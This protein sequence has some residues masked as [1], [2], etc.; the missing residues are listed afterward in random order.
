MARR[1][2]GDGGR[3]GR[4]AA[5]AI[6]A[7]AAAAAVVLCR[8]PAA[9]AFKYNLA[10][11]TEGGTT[12]ATLMLSEGHMFASH[13][14]PF[15]TDGVSSISAGIRLTPAAGGT[16][17]RSAAIN[18]WAVHLDAE[19]YSRVGYVVPDVDGGQMEL[20][21]CTPSLYAQRVCGAGTV[22]GGLIVHEDAD[23][24][25][26]LAPALA[27]LTP[28]AS[29]VD[30]AA[31]ME[32]AVAGQQYLVVA[33]CDTSTDVPARGLP[34]LH[35]DVDLAFINP[36]GYLP[37]AAYGLLPFYGTLFIAYTLL[38]AG[39]GAIAALKRRY[40]L[41]LQLAV[42]GVMLAGV[43]EMALFF[44]TYRSKNATGVPTPCSECGTPTSDYMAAVVWGVL[45]RAVSR[46]LLLA[47]AAGFGVVH[48]TLTR[49]TT[50]GIVALCTGYAVFGVVASMVKETTYDPKPNAWQLPVMM[51]DS[52]IGVLIYSSLISL[53]R[54][55][56]TTGQTAKLAMYTKLMWVLVAN[57][58]A[59]FL[60][61]IIFTFIRMRFLPLTWSWLFLL[62]S[63][64]DILYFVI[65]AAVR[66]F[67]PCCPTLSPYCCTTHPRAPLP[68]LLSC[69]WQSSGCR[70][71]RRSSTRGTRRGRL[72]TTARWAAVP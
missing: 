6:A 13:D 57:L 52:T 35:F 29:Y 21:C 33:A 55:L 2:N 69:R 61:A 18:L 72:P 37:G 19:T 54:M 8:A 47:V 20:L 16:G 43:V 26:K 46:G 59:W 42:G 53:R 24:A 68:P 25:R 45:K 40:L 51:L 66:R 44:F 10:H 49:R 22:V 5:V 15:G 7:G 41:R 71:R 9:A 62:D 58:T 48:P 17:S 31:V 30:L 14:G 39:Y 34:A 27:V 32:V 56:A 64:W 38:T 1:G 12:Q 67:L 28:N 70:V 3:P 36:A 60:F 63:C 11:D 4:V 23:A 65:L 50:A